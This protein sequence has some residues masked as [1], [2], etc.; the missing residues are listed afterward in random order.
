MKKDQLFTGLGGPPR[1]AVSADV[2][3]A[4]PLR[5]YVLDALP[6]DLSAVAAGRMT[7]RELADRQGQLLS[8][9]EPHA[10]RVDDLAVAQVIQLDL[11]FMVNGFLPGGP[12]AVPR[13]L[14]DA[15]AA[16]CARFPSLDPHMSYELLIDV[17][18]GEWHRSGDM[19]V[20][21]E[22]ELGGL[23]RDFYLGH[24][25]SEPTVRSAFGLLCT[26]LQEPDSVDATETLGGVL[27]GLEEFRLYMAQYSKLTRDA[28][29]S[30]RQYHMGHPGG[31]RGA[32]GAFMPSVQ[33]LELALLAP[34][35]EYEVYLDQSMA[36]F[37]NWSRPLIAEWRETSRKGDNVVDAVLDGRLKL[38]DDATATLLNVIDKFADFRMV[39]L[40]V[41][42]KTIP[43]AFPAGSV[44]TKKGIARQTGEAD[45]L[46]DQNPGTSGFS[47]HN[48]LVNSVYRLLEAHRSVASLGQTPT[49]GRAN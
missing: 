42:R 24:H 20:F 49:D 19:R 11:L 16:Q 1:G 33:L 13:H 26:L 41:T 12:G 44:V 36:Y 30:F 3:V 2:S 43:E 40:G 8:S 21:T 9:L 14:S 29:N 47:V 15:V 28:F 27:R 31:P 4:S 48:V 17:N 39:H 22:G 34:T 37:P 46:D 32:S 45:I 6:A 7:Y 35:T 23:E 10:L 18:A 5:S 38:N 25:L